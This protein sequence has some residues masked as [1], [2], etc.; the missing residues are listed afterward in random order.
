MKWL[1]SLWSLKDILGLII[2]R[3][4]IRIIIEIIFHWSG[5]ATGVLDLFLSL[6]SHFRSQLAHRP[7]DGGIKNLWNIDRF[8]PDYTVHWDDVFILSALGTWNLAEYFKFKY[9][10]G[11][12]DQQILCFHGTQKFI[13]VFTAPHYLSV[14]RGSS[15]QSTGP[16]PAFFLAQ[17]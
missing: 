16:Y 17:I 8:V 13:I 1:R 3:L 10:R 5:E 15:F 7:E 14:P 12:A 6:N 9:V 4:E 11:L 2:L